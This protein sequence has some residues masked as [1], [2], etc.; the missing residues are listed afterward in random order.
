M[1]NTLS[2][3]AVRN[4]AIRKM[5][6]LTHKDDRLMVTCGVDALGGDVVSDAL[7]Q[8]I[9]FD[10]FNEDN[11]PYG[12]HD[13]LSFD[14]LTGDRAFFKIDDYN[15]HDGIRCVLTILLASEY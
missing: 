15:G 2:E 8:I 12:E 7:K 14:L 3:L 4:D 11:D 10:D 13:F 5:L 9:E 1:P 6:P